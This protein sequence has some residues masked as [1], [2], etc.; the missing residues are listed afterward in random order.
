MG[1]ATRCESHRERCIFRTIEVARSGMMIAIDK[2][3]QD[4]VV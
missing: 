4:V 2:K 3:Q 1:G